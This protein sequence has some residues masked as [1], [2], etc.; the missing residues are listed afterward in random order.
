MLVQIRL[1]RICWLAF[2]W[3]QSGRKARGLRRR[4]KRRS[5]SPQYRRTRSL[6]SEACSW[7]PIGRFLGRIGAVAVRYLG[8]SIV[9]INGMQHLLVCNELA[10]PASIPVVHILLN[11]ILLYY[12]GPHHRPF[13]L[14]SC[15]APS[16]M[17]LKCRYYSFSEIHPINEA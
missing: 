10:G 17:V 9:H 1:S 7:K 16:K 4:R 6:V 11:A 5:R 13:H 2:L 15:N 3:N 12:W 8:S 14:R